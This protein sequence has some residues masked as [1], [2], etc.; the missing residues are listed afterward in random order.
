MQRV[1]PAGCLGGDSP[2]VILVDE[3]VAGRVGLIEV[4]LPPEVRGVRHSDV[5]VV[6]P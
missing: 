1:K 3:E 2:V 6:G 4:R 5:R